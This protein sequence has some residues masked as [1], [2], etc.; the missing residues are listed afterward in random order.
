MSDA[1]RSTK[2]HPGEAMEPTGNPMKDGVGAASWAKDRADHPDLTLEGEPKIQPMSIL[3][4]WEVHPK[5]PDPLGASVV[6]AEGVVVGTVDDLWVDRSEPAIRFLSVKLA[7]GGGS[8]LLPMGYAKV[9][10]TRDGVIIKVVAIYA[11][12]FAD[13]PQPKHP[14]RITLLEEDKVFAWFAGGYRYA[15]ATRLDPLF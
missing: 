5:D 11:A 15:D 14:D 6:D 12:Q 13:V 1:I 4:G 10:K 7:Q 9:K 8:R 2:G 3:S